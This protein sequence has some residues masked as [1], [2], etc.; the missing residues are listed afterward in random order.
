MEH[1]R[2]RQTEILNK[3]PPVFSH[4]QLYVASSRTGN[5]TELKYAIK[6]QEGHGSQYTDNVVWKKVLLLQFWPRLIWKKKTHSC[7]E[8]KQKHR[9]KSERQREREWERGG[10]R[11]SERDR[12]RSP[13]DTE[14]LHYWVG[15]SF[16]ILTVSEYARSPKPR[17]F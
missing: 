6:K 10:E 2:P 12:Y 16:P 5:P 14:G 17:L 7:P 1:E 8:L 9:I 15:R 13:H 11:E 4:G 3:V